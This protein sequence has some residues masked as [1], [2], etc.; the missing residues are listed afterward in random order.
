MKKC[1]MNLEGEVKVCE[2]EGELQALKEKQYKEVL[3]FS[4]MTES[5]A[6]VVD[7]KKVGDMKK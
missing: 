6:W 1:M 5:S 7:K 2:T 4:W 3:D